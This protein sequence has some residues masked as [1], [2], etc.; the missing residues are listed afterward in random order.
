MI[1]LLDDPLISGVALPFVAALTVALAARLAGGGI[2]RR[3]AVAVPLAFL[4]AYLPLL[5]LPPFPPV[6]AAH[7]VGY[8]IAGMVVLGLVVEGRGRWAALLAG[9]AGLVAAVGWIGQRPLSG[10]GETAWIVA[11]AVSGA[12][13]LALAALMREQARPAVGGA[14][15]AVTALGLAALAF[16]GA[17]A[18][19]MQAAIALAAAAGGFALL[20]LFRPLLP[21]GAAGVLGAVAALTALAAQA[22]FFTRLDR[23]A[24]LVLGAAI[25]SLFLAGRMPAVR[26]PGLLSPILAALAAAVPVAAAAA[27]AWYA[28]SSGAG[29]RA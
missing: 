28:Q 12:G 1:G 9:A 10:P 21:F 24:M 14:V 11:A 2:A 3:G 26:R 7:K 22:A 5:G 20:N 6:A 25:P 18:S 8:V 19:I 29:W 27:L 23:S 16:F 4:L 17:S 15:L 13:I